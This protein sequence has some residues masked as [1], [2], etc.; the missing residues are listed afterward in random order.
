[1]YTRMPTKK[2]TNYLLISALSNSSCWV[3]QEDGVFLGSGPYR[4]QSPLE[5][6]DFLSVH[7]SVRP[8]VRPFPPSRPGWLAL[9]PAWRALRPA[10]LALRPAWLG[11]RPVW[12]ALGPLSG[13]D[14]W[15]YRQ[16]IFPFYR[17]SSPTG[18]AAQK[19]NNRQSPK[20]VAKFHPQYK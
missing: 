1:M 5:W 15:M 3:K 7:L 4:G 10:W 18:A 14:R 2:C 8:S 16:K 19:T 11:L 12:L 17:T 6:G 20:A 9:R 13:R